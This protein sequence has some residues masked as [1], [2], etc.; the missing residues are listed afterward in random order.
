MLR[1]LELKA[2]YE[3]GGWPAQPRPDIRPP[4]GWSIPLITSLGRPRSHSLSPDG[5]RIA[6]IWDQ[7]D[8]SDLYIIPREGGWPARMTPDRAP[9]PYWFDDAPQWSPNGELIAYTEK[10]HVW[11]VPV[12]GGM[13]KKITSFTTH[14]DT[15]RW[16]PNSY[17]LLVT[18][19][20]DERQ[21]ILLT[22][23]EGSWPL[24]VSEGPGHDYEPEASPDGRYITYVHSPMEDL[25]RFD[26]M[27]AD[28]ENDTTR[29]LSGT[30]E[31]EATY[32][33]WSPDG[34]LIAFISER[35]GHYELFVTDPHSG[36]ER[37]ITHLG[38]D[39]DDI[40]WSPDGTRIACTINRRGSLNLAII[41]VD[42]GRVDDLRT[43]PGVHMRPKW[44][45]DGK[46]LTF[47][48]ESP[49]LP[50]DIY[51]MDLETHHVRQLTFSNLPA[52]Q[53]LDLVMPEEVIYR[54]YDGLEIPSFIYKPLNPNGAAIVF[55]HGGP[56][57]QYLLEWDIWAQYMS[58]KG[59]TWLAPNF[60]GSNGYGTEF[61]R[62]NH[63]TWG[64][65][66]TED[67]LFAADYL[68][69]LEWIDPKRIAIYGSSY[70]SYLAVCALAYDPKYRFACGIAKYGDC[71]ILTSWAQSE[72][73]T[74]ED[75]ER[76]MG[77][78]ADDRE[79]YDIGSPVR[80]AANIER[81]LL[82]VHGLLDKIVHPLQSEELVE[83]L[84]NEGKTFEYKTYPDEG[85]GLLRRKNQLDF[86]HHMERFCDWYLL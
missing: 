15:P 20:R 48:F 28:I 34:R 29:L 16:M 43:D 38:Y 10:N 64:V 68:A 12:S 40:A 76:M 22:D 13:P 45:P 69:A 78:P 41:E 39:V 25:N 42:S 74:R 53:V 79:G 63:N 4:D 24:P 7:S 58:A 17:H 8:A 5:K 67:C 19:E 60:R 9:R 1:E 80:H 52:L 72:R 18:V 61:E 30:P 73:G 32:P 86:Y 66:D 37:Q 83:A 44:C 11:I 46:T 51:V 2:K 65:G 6:Y 82:I 49:V 55:P 27:L 54:S 23:I 36:V 81:P 75:M 33:C 14:A 71:N 77:H 84:K 3:R 56:T 31:M 35:P 47:E 59:Y 85:H 70:G 26:I 21:R 62:A 50:H 57:S